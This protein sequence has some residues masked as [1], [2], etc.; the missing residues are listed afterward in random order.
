MC[1]SREVVYFDR[2][3]LKAVTLHNAVEINHVIVLLG[4]SFLEITA[5]SVQI[6]LVHVFLLGSF[7]RKL[8]V[9]DL[10]QAAYWTGNGRTLTS[11]CR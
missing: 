2:S 7:E 4:Q 11:G 1:S 6:K 10:L 9:I 3:A 8:E 5:N